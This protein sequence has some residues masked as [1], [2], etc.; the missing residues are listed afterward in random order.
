MIE[1]AEHGKTTCTIGPEDVQYI[2]SVASGNTGV[3]FP[4]PPK[5]KESL[6]KVSYTKEGKVTIKTG[7]VVGIIPLPS[8]KV[9]RITPKVGSSHG[10]FWLLCQALGFDNIRL[11]SR[12][13]EVET[14]EDPLEWLFL[15]LRHEIRKLVQAGLRKDYVPVEETAGV[16]RGRVLPARTI[17]ETRGL[18]HKVTC[19]YDDFTPDVFDNQVLRL[20]LRAAAHH[21]PELRHQLLGTD[22]LFDGEVTYERADLHRAA[23]NLKRL[24]DQQH[25]GRKRYV[26]AHTLAYMVL[27]VLSAGGDGQNW[28]HPGIL[29]DMSKLFEVGLRQMLDEEFGH[30]RFTDAGRSQVAFAPIGSPPVVKGMKPDIPLRNLIVDAKYKSQPLTIR[31]QRL[32]PPD[33][34]VYQ[35]HTYSYFGERPCALVYAMGTKTE[36]EHK[37]ALSF[38]LNQMNASSWPR[39]GLFGLDLSGSSFVELEQQRVNLIGQLGKFSEGQV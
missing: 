10:V 24:L 14:R 31:G 5:R 26:T 15:I 4:E 39:V 29:L 11:L 38:G 8:G 6:V 13:D 33:G 19:L 2:E 22:A 16:V 27:R 21:A 7:G 3:V 37:A 25:P 1:V 32:Q 18:A 34:D 17:A 23:A 36:P 12:L 20:A 35:A 28:R 30:Y 9:L